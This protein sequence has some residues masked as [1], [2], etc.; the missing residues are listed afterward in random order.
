MMVDAELEGGLWLSVSEIARI[1]NKS[2]QGISKRV[3]ALIAN[4]KITS[5][6][7]QNGT[8][9][10]NLAAFRHAIG[11]TGDPAKEAAAATVRDIEPAATAEAPA[12][13]EA[14]APIEAAP[15][16][17]AYRDAATRKAQFEADLAEIKLKEKRGEVVSV[18]RLENVV[19]EVAEA[20]IRHLDLTRYADVMASSVAKDGIVGARGRFKEISRELREKI[21]G[22]MEKIASGIVPEAIEGGASD[23]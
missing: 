13:A 3:A 14:T 21:A 7:G 4:G 9:L 20:I 8:K 6:P 19:G 22:D 10:V 1:E 12:P 11:E 5:K 2:R 17:T 15:A 16:N 18:E 23:T